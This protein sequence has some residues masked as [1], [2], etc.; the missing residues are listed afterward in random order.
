MYI[1]V[2]IYVGK[3]ESLFS[4]LCLLQSIWQITQSTNYCHHTSIQNIVVIL[5]DVDVERNKER[6]WSDD[7][8]IVWSNVYISC[9]VVRVYMYKKASRWRV[10]GWWIERSYSKFV[11]M[12]V[13]VYINARNVRRTI[14]CCL[15]NLYEYVVC[16]NIKPIFVYKTFDI[17]VYIPFVFSFYFFL[18]DE[19]NTTYYYYYYYYGDNEQ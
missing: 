13:Y 4:F 1:Y 6:S 15:W 16:R 18:S 9:C 2:Y 8:D 19:Y 14:W 3:W 10:N 11:Y 5:Y 17:Y 12:Y 7:N